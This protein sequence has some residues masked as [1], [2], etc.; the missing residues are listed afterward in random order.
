[1]K[2]EEYGEASRVSPKLWVLLFVPSRT[3]VLASNTFFCITTL[4]NNNRIIINEICGG[5]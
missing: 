1:M 2:N 5:K 3:L 4:K